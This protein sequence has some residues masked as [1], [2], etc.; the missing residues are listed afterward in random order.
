MSEH[1]HGSENTSDTRE[2]KPIDKKY[3]ILYTFNEH[4]PTIVI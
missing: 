4:L 3:T 1:L 2:L